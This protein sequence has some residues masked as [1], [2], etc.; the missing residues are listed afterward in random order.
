MTANTARSPG[1]VR[2]GLTALGA[3]GTALRLGLLGGVVD[4]STKGAFSASASVP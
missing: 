1:P 2:L 3:I 4:V